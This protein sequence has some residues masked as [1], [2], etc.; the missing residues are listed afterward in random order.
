MDLCS[1]FYGGFPDSRSNCPRPFLVRIPRS[2]KIRTQIPTLPLPWHPCFEGEISPTAPKQQR[3]AT[4][5]IADPPLRR[6]S[7]HAKTPTSS[8]TMFLER[9]HLACSSF[10]IS[11]TNRTVHRCRLGARVCVQSD[12]YQPR[13]AH[14]R[15]GYGLRT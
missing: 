15:S 6:S 3:P 14:F 7:R 2:H 9:E 10:C 8:R 1:S 4:Q 12:Q 11:V 13:S 5:L